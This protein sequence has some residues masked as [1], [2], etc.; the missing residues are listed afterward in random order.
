MKYDDAEYYF[1]DFETDLP[2]ENGGRHIGLFLEWAILRGLASERLMAHAGA[3]RDGATSGL[4]LLFD[5]CD[6]KLWDQDLNAEGNAFA[7]DYYAKH[8][9]ADFIAAMNLKPEAPVD[10]IFGADLTQ[11]R[12]ARVLWQLDRRYSDWRRRFGLPGNDALLERLLAVI[13]P[14]AEACGFAC[15]PRSPAG[16]WKLVEACATFER[17]GPWGRQRFDLIA[18][19][20][21]EWFYGVRVELTVSIPALS[22]AIY[23]E[24]EA[25]VGNVTAVQPAAAIGFLRLAEGWNG[26]LQVYD[27]RS[28]GFWIFRDEDIDPLAQ[29]LAVRL[30]RFAL[31][32]LRDLDGIDA[33]ALAFGMRPAAASP[34]HD[35]DDPYPALL[36]AEMARHPRLGAMLIEAEQAVHAI[37]AKKRAFHQEGVLKLV[38]RIRQRSKALIK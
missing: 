9:V 38:A 28:P 21:P 10:A 6:G 19:D 8:H 32:A 23:A 5:H 29:W 36:A 15:L 12:R 4:D 35:A 17:S 33:I 7:A 30:R 25:D 1:L 13:R 14:V 26:P 20:N 18:S 37:D 16:T 27:M 24:K 34:I 3:L 22:A 31:P 11:Q 2:N